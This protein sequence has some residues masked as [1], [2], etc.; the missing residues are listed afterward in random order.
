MHRFFLLP[1]LITGFWLWANRLI[2]QYLSNPASDPNQKSNHTPCPTDS[3]A[4]LMRYRMHEFAALTR[5]IHEHTQNRLTPSQLSDS[6]QHYYL[7]ERFTGKKLSDPN[8]WQPGFTTIDSLF[9]LAYEQFYRQPTRQNLTVLI[10]YCQACHTVL[11]PGPLATLD[12]WLH[13]LNSIPQ[14]HPENYH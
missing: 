12:E 14:S 3:L 6:L 2:P 10:R 9:Y 7:P 11:C 8:L 1:F 5:L 4:C 13:Q